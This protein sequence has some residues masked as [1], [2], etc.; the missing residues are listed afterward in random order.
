MNPRK[1]PQKNA[2]HFLRLLRLILR[3]LRLKT[4][5]LTAHTLLHYAQATKISNVKYCQQLWQKRI[6]DLMPLKVIGQNS[7]D[8]FWHKFL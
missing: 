7:C 2:L 4:R 6:N 3:F 1:M 5:T 8:F